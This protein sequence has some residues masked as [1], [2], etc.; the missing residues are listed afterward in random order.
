MKQ[1]VS[2]EKGHTDEFFWPGKGKMSRKIQRHLFC[3]WYP[4]VVEREYIDP[5]FPR[6]NF[7]VH[8]S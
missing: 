3:I 4:L 6:L 7:P 1:T 5:A 2:G 8:G